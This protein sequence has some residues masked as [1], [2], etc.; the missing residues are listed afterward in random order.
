MY[1]YTDEELIEEYRTKKGDRRRKAFDRLYVRHV[2]PLRHYFFFTL[3]RDQE[4]ARDFAHD[5]FIK[6]LESPEKFD[7]DKPFKPWVFRVASNM[8]KNEFRRLEVVGK[9]Q[10]Q[11]R[12]NESKEAELNEKESWLHECIRRLD[13]EYRSLIVLRFKIKLSIREM[14]AIYECPEGTIKS[15]LFYATRELSRYYKE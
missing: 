6:L 8:C 11:L 2:D 15:R 1:R 14:A 12:E 5:L 3:G 9:Y 7:T 13:S 4:K 10:A